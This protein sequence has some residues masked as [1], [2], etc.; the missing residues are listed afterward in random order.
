MST[1][2]FNIKLGRNL[3]T[4]SAVSLLLASPAIAQDQVLQSDTSASTN[5]QQNP[6]QQN[7]E[8][9]TM[10]QDQDQLLVWREIHVVMD[11]RILAAGLNQEQIFK[12]YDNN[13]DEALD[14][15]EFDNFVAGLQ[16]AEVGTNEG[17]TANVSSQSKP[18]TASELSANN[19]QQN[20]DTNQPNLANAQRQNPDQN[21]SV[22]IRQGQKL[23][24]E[25][26]LSRQDRS[27]ALTNRPEADI[28]TVDE[29][30][31]QLSAQ[32]TDE[33]V[34][35]RSFETEADLSE[36]T[37][38]EAGSSRALD[39]GELSTANSTNNQNTNPQEDG[40]AVIVMEGETARTSDRSAQA[41]TSARG[42]PSENAQATEGSSSNIETNVREN[43]VVNAGDLRRIYEAL[44]DSP[45]V[46]ADGQ[47][48]GTIADVV[49][50]N[51]SG[52]VGL[53]VTTGGIMGIGATKLVAPVQDITVTDDN[54]VWS[55][56][57]TKKELK[58]SERYNSDNYDRITGSSQAAEDA[59]SEGLTQR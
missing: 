52:D 9:Q 11:P 38:I 28:D 27:S 58:Q 31:N 49:V 7:P 25:Q 10:D 2:M 39:P 16:Q 54:V 43:E 23:E 45:V 42:E 8:F 41:T 47:N 53:V 55:T 46:N 24:T 30:D 22:D 29:A 19:Q 40:T 33:A 18:A 15:E 21:A 32:D 56:S 37:N 57:K 5:Q 1:E 13:K 3:L 34:I 12:Q 35:A 48:I 20:I 14:E 36:A 6:Q 17:A 51:E 50:N 4:A 26:E 59:R 44:E